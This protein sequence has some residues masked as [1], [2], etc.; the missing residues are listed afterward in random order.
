[1]NAQHTNSLLAVNP[2]QLD[3]IATADGKF[4]VARATVLNPV[5]HTIGNARRLVACWNACEG[6][7][8]EQI[9][10][11]ADHHEKVEAQ[12]DALL[13][14]LQEAKANAGN[15]EAVYRITSAAIAK[16]AGGQL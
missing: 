9:G 16:S 6:L 10:L 13:A 11:I 7:S 15:P 8:T 4:E 5:A 3:Q 1:M 14:A 2:L 12:R